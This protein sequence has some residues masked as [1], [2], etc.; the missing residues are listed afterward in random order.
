MDFKMKIGTVSS[1]I[2]YEPGIFTGI[3]HPKM[4]QLYY[5]VMFPDASAFRQVPHQVYSQFWTYSWELD[6]CAL[7]TH[8]SKCDQIAS[9][10]SCWI[11]LSLKKLRCSLLQRHP[12]SVTS[13]WLPILTLIFRNTLSLVY[14]ASYQ[15]ISQQN[16]SLQLNIS[17][18]NLCTR[19]LFIFFLHFLQKYFKIMIC[20][21]SI[22]KMRLIIRTS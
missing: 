2:S 3:L 22:L 18:C 10:H 13:L 6:H 19:A 7:H 4:G 12:V 1:G 16:M 11:T 21:L 9:L 20:C 17:L 14:I 8:F 15:A 5:N